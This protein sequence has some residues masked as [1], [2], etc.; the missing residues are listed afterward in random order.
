V[1]PRSVLRIARWEVTKGAGGID[2]R[3]V[4]VAV[5]GLA[6]VLALVPLVTAG[7][8]ALDAGIYRVGVDPG[9]QLHGPVEEDATLAVR[10]P[11]AEA[12]DEGDLE[13]LVRES[14]VVYRNTEK[15]RAA[16][17]ELRSAVEGYNDRRVAVEPNQS[18]AYPVDVTVRYVSRN[19]TDVVVPDGGGDGPD[20][21]DGGGTP[22]GGDESGGDGSGTDGGSGDS[23]ASSDGD[24]RSDDSG[25]DDGSS[26]DGNLGVPSFGGDL[27]GTGQSSGR[28]G[29][30]S[31]PFPFQ[32]LVLAF[33]F[34]LPLNFVIQAYGSSM[35][36]ERID[37][38]G[39]PL[40]VAPVSP[41]DIVAGKTLPYFAGAMGIVVAIALV[42]G[43][44][45]L[46][47]LAMTPL[48]G[49]FLGTT[50]VGAMFARSFKEL[51][52]V[53]VSVSVFLTAYAFVPAIF[54]DVSS[55]ALVSPL[56]L[57]VR[58]LAG[59]AVSAGEVAF[60]T[61]PPTL[62]ALVLFGLGAGVY[63]EEDLFTQRPIHLKLLDALAAP[64]GRVRGVPLVTALLVPFVFV[65]E[66]LAVAVLFALPGELSIPL[67]LASVALVEEL[68]KSLPVY[69]GFVHARFPRTA[70]SAV[71][72]GAASGAGFFLA[73][74]L[75]LV[76]Q[77]VGLPDLRTRAGP[78]GETA[79]QTG[80]GVDGPVLALVLLLAPLA[81]HVAT[82]TLSALGATRGRESYAV[83][84]AAAIVVHVAYNLA[85][86][87]A[88]V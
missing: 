62:A 66:L 48:A 36:R 24:E 81:L 76:V 41:R 7:G 30:I 68:A 87:R 53:T 54:A 6:F 43:G 60:A 20:A 51:T 29:D 38:R 69:A 83:G 16:V 44:G 12:F 70:R 45:P 74:K 32:S 50:F 80:L 56:T 67:L 40:L 5:A 2:R 79:F 13:V 78:I 19:V 14:H 17:A 85:V 64:V 11:D 23:E 10:D 34:V 63:R 88:L 39:E 77:L 57:V 25:S 46:S 4:A 15:G 72:A 28:P 55:V 37:R 3:T 75:T 71:L 65:T 61:L 86:V 59:Q 18:A 26:G 52:F 9:H 82:A 21:G 22:A 31:P 42:A 35:L 58:D 8:V 1:N 47:V 33:A 73:E 49:L 27:F 84:L